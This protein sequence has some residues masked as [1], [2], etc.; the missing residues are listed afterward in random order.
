MFHIVFLDPGC[1]C[2]YMSLW[3]ICRPPQTKIL[4]TDSSDCMYVMNC[5][6][7]EITSPE[8]AFE[9]LFKGK[10][11]TSLST[12]NY[13]G[14]LTLTH[15]QNTRTSTFFNLFDKKK[16]I[17]DIHCLYYILF[18]L[19]KKKKLIMGKV[20]MRVYMHYYFF[21]QHKVNLWFYGDL[22]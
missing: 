14:S 11:L 5:V 6:E 15:S 9:V 13:P 7:V 18:H 10:T 1:C 17:D 21:L 12:K 20:C 19:F 4:R 16:Q 2:V 8:E 22:L 3:L